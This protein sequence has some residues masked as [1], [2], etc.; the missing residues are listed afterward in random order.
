M[1]GGI[2]RGRLRL[3]A[4]PALA[5]RG[6]GAGLVLKDIGITFSRLRATE[7]GGMGMLADRDCRADIFEIWGWGYEDSSAWGMLPLH[8]PEND[9]TP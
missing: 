9:F 1:G 4:V 5:R 3:A 8:E 7:V 6:R 2:P